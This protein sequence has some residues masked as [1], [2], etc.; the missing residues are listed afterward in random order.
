MLLPQV[1]LKVQVAASDGCELRFK[2]L[3][4]PQS[5]TCPHAFTEKLAYDQEVQ[6]QRAQAELMQGKKERDAY[7]AAVHKV[8]RSSRMQRP[9]MSLCLIITNPSPAGPRV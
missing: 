3:L 5:C 7:V 2:L 8:C 4:Q 6:R 1:S 9:C